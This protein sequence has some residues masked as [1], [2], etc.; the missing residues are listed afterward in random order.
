MIVLLTIFG[1]S[2]FAI[3]SSGTALVILN[4]KIKNERKKEKQYNVVR[5]RMAKNDY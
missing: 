5:D 4:G 2:I 1:L 3:L